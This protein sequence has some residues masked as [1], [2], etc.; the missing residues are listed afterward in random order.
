MYAQ[1]LGS[2]IA[3]LADRLSVGTSK[4]LQLLDIGYLRVPTTTLT[5]ECRTFLK[6][7]EEKYFQ[8]KTEIF[9]PES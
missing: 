6:L 8:E 3:P 5:E 4:V 7:L 2:R 9:M 1:E